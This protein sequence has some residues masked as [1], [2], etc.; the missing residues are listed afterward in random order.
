MQLTSAH[1]QKALREDQGCKTP[2]GCPM[3]PSQSRHHQTRWPTT[4]VESAK[5]GT[6]QNP[7]TTS[8]QTN[9]ECGCRQTGR[10]PEINEPRAR[11]Y[12]KFIPGSAH[13][14]NSWPGQGKVCR[15][16]VYIGQ[17]RAT[18]QDKRMPAPV[19]P[20]G[21]LRERQIAQ[22]PRKANQLQAI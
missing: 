18:A 3:A 5:P 6:F 14:R 12:P 21:A 10:T 4:K 15:T 8:C 13:R 17:T 11:R 9:R 20:Q 22:P 16:A 7:G 1:Q 2:V 19:Q